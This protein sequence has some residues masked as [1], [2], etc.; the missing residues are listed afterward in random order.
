MTWLFDSP[1]TIG[2]LGAGI[3]VSLALLWLKTP[4]KPF[5]AA[6]VI[7]VLLT[8]VLLVVEG[9]VETEEEKITVMLKGVTAAVE[10]EDT[11]EVLTYIHSTKQALRNEVER[12]GP[13]FD[14]KKVKITKV[15]RIEVVSES[16]ATAEFNV[17]ISV[18]SRELA[19][20]FNDFRFVVLSLLKEGNDWKVAGYAHYA[21]TEG[22]KKPSARKRGPGP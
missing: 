19:G 4:K 11:V 18:T 15:K 13:Q 2:L 22:M 8:V 17:A 21:I 7:A 16:E 5:L 3:V 6:M 12:R 1:A 20:E 10:T 9:I 14:F